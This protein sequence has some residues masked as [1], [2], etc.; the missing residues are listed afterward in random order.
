[1]KANKLYRI[2]LA[3]VALTSFAGCAA[4]SSDEVDGD[5]VAAIPADETLSVASH[6]WVIYA[7]TI[8]NHATGLCLDGYNGGGNAKPYMYTCNKA[9]PYQLWVSTKSGDR[10]CNVGNGLCLDGFVNP[11]G[12][13]PYLFQNN[14][15]NPYQK[16]R[17]M[18]GNIG[19]S[20]VL[21]NAGTGTCLDGY[22][23]LGQRPYLYACNGSNTHQ[24]WYWGGAE[25]GPQGP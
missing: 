13:N 19:F 14:P 20:S 23:G 10:V 6:P 11:S 4:P 17:L 12:G 15:T 8:R 1:M 22:V 25:L 18:L 9:N 24:L 3:A 21:R 2:A 5:E 16:W 7:S